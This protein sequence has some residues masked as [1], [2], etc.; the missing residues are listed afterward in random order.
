MANN[1]NEVGLVAR[2]NVFE[3]LKNLTDSIRLF[4]SHLAD[5]NVLSNISEKL[6]AIQ[7]K[8]DKNVP[9]DD[10]IESLCLSDLFEWRKQLLD[11]SSKKGDSAFLSESLEYIDLFIE[12][13]RAKD[14]SLSFLVMCSNDELS[15]LIYWI[16]TE[17]RLDKNGAVIQ[18]PRK[19][20]P[21]YSATLTEAKDDLHEVLPMIE[22]CILMEENNKA[23]K[24]RYRNLLLKVCDSFKVNYHPLSSIELLEQELLQKIWDLPFEKLTAMDIRQIS[25]EQFRQ[26]KFYTE[27]STEYNMAIPC[28]LLIAA[29]RK[30]YC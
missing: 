22:E 10:I 15:S 17:A 9:D 29:Y 28:V 6:N 13:A 11:I 18:S 14:T 7:K 12:L 21:Y 23:L 16:L 24:S 5:V 26:F 3:T 8:I 19:I 20:R 2:L 30:K 25:L 27:W 4:S 1:G